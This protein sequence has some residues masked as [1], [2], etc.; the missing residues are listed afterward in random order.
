MTGEIFRL[1]LEFQEGSVLCASKLYRAF[2]FRC[3]KEL[4]G[5][6]EVESLVRVPPFL[7]SLSARSGKVD[8]PLTLPLAFGFPV[9][10][11]NILL[12]LCWPQAFIFSS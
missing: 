3:L 10:S 12:E 8:L 9:I 2:I 5:C 11:K 4:S 6:K 1:T 7:G